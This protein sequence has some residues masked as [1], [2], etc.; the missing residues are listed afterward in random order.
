MSPAASAI[1][2]MIM[3]EGIDGSTAYEI[4][5][6]ILDFERHLSHERQVFASEF[7][8]PTPDS[9]EQLASNEPDGKDAELQM[10]YKLSQQGLHRLSK[11]ERDEL[12]LY[13]SALKLLIRTET[14]KKKEE[15]STS[16]RYYRRASNRL[17]KSLRRAA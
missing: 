13:R 4:S 17:I 8:P 12:S 7:M 1:S 2:A 16:A 3:A 11:E 5:T 14:Q 6:R 9:D 15:A 10:L